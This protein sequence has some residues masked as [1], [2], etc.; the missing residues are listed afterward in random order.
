MAELSSQRLLRFARSL[1]GAQD[2]GELVRAAALEIREA[3]GY[4]HTWLMI[5]EDE[6]SER[7]RMLAYEGSQAERV[8]D[9]A[10]VLTVRG[11]AFLE[12]LVAS[13]EPVVIEDARLDPRTDKVKVEALQNR[14]LINLPL[15]MLDKP[16]GM[17]G[18]GTFGDEGCR[19]P[20]APELSY[21]VGIASQ[22][23]VAAARVRYTQE[24]LRAE[25]ERRKLERK[26]AQLQRIDSLGLL[27]GGVA[28]DFNNL[29][30]V[31]M[32]SVSLAQTVSRDPGV[33]A[34][35]DAALTATQHARELTAQLLAMGRSQPLQLQL[36]DVNTRIEQLSSMLRH[37]FP[38]VI[39]SELHLGANL[40]AIEGDGTQL[41]RVLM[42]LCI[43]ARDAMPAGGQLTIRTE[44]TELNSSFVQA[45]P[46][47]KPGRFV[48]ITVRDNGSGM[49]KETLERVFEPFF[50]T[51][52]SLG[53]TGLGLAVAHGIVSQHGGLL[54]AHSEPN[55]GST[56]EVYLP[57]A[58]QR[59]HALRVSA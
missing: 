32:S 1:Q 13:E 25:D 22:L 3:L 47:A 7:F 10:P 4:A 57:V 9:V 6:T 26:L 33:L 44:H 12:A 48:L 27:A 17:L 19:A 29:L 15:T 31:I 8:W 49:S 11:D 21:L 46:W 2:F 38:E 14:T 54:H 56:F 41:D 24:R 36:L 5:A 30:T 53:G 45:N 35:L 23:T 50:T 34:D 55:V 20:T 58:E 28:H 37:V 59:A 43:N 42:N 16:L 52:S 40:P 18:I 39:A 51:K